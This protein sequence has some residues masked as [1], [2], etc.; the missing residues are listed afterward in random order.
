MRNLSLHRRAAAVAVMVVS[1]LAMLLPV[2]WLAGLSISPRGLFGRNTSPGQPQSDGPAG[3]GEEAVAPE[4]QEAQD[5]EDTD[6][7]LSATTKPRSRLRGLAGWTIY[8]AIIV[9]AILLG[10]RIMVWALGSDHPIATVSGDSMWPTLKQGD[11]VLLKGVSHIEEVEVGDIIGFR[12]TDGLA[13]HRIV[14]IEGDEIIARGDA[15]FRD[16]PPIGI[17]DVVGRVPTILGKNARIPYLGHM[18][19]LLGPLVKSTNELD[20]GPSSAEDQGNHL[21]AR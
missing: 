6:A 8:L 12:H 4:I 14:R 20:G 7:A 1:A 3:E 2:L 15:N 13:I 17:E 18:T 10:P 16:D 9:V 21:S 5:A 19:F 11:I